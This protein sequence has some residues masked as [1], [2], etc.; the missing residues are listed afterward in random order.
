[1]SSCQDY[2]MGHQGSSCLGQWESSGKRVHSKE[3]RVYGFEGRND[4]QCSVFGQFLR[5]LS[6]MG[7]TE[8]MPGAREKD[9]TS[10]IWRTETKISG[11][12]WRKRYHEFE[13]PIIELTKIKVKG[14]SPSTG[15]SSLLPTITV[16]EKGLWSRL[17][18][19]LF[20]LHQRT[21]K[22]RVGKQGISNILIETEMK[23]FWH[24][25]ENSKRWLGR[26][27]VDNESCEIANITKLQKYSAYSFAQQYLPRAYYDVRHCAR[28]QN[29]NVEPKHLLSL[30]LSPA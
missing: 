26:G 27:R 22:W 19:T 14:F 18:E 15:E 8:P 30:I 29:Y 20:L 7:P 28:C 6:S 24:F 25:F 3:D 4:I 12:H 1:M 13:F 11:R 10:H 17:P 23:I 5:F 9:A 16:V 21:S 2:G